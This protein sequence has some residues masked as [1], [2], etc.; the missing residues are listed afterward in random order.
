MEPITMSVGQQ[1]R[2]EKIAR[3]REYFDP[4]DRPEIYEWSV[5]DEKLDFKLMTNQEIE[6]YL[7]SKI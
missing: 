3:L 2:L 7:R 6:A 4:G 1:K 5:E